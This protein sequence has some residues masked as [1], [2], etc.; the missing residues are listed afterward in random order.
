[1]KN[2]VSKLGVQMVSIGSESC[3]G[4]SVQIQQAKKMPPTS[5]GMVGYCPNLEYLGDIY[6]SSPR[7]PIRGPAPRLAGWIPAFAGMT[8]SAVN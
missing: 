7:T 1:M 2:G 8:A 5:G 6:K 3:E 4:C